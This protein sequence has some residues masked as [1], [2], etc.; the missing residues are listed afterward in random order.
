MN[1]TA[2]YSRG[3]SS[4]NLYRSFSRNMTPMSVTS[5][6][7]ESTRP[8]N[9]QHIKHNMPM[10][11]TGNMLR[12]NKSDH[13]A[14]W[15]TLLSRTNGPYKPVRGEVMISQKRVTE[16]EQSVRTL[17]P[18]LQQPPRIPQRKA[19]PS[20]SNKENTYNVISPPANVVHPAKK[21]T[22]CSRYIPCLS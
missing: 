22:G 17:Q 10:E 2:T 13:P 18:H 19:P 14:T 15:D 3:L 1:N 9:F 8:L 16:S 4:T 6:F 11:L 12:W 20:P 21:I 5:N 7:Y